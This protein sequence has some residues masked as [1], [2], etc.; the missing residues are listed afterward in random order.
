M[1]ATKESLNNSGGK[2]EEGC[3][4]EGEGGVSQSLREGTGE[5]FVGRRG[6]EEGR[7]RSVDGGGATYLDEL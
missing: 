3:K 6:R 7:R 4:Q 5:N 1:F 2:E